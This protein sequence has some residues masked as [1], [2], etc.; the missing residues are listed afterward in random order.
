MKTH[1]PKAGSQALAHYEKGRAAWAAMAERATHVYVADISYGRIPKRRGHWSDKLA[2]IDKDLDAMRA[3][4]A[5]GGAAS[6]GAAAAIA[7]ASAAPNRPKVTCTHTAPQQFSPG[8]PLVL[9][10]T[11][12]GDVSALLHYRHVNQA[13]RWQSMPMT[14][15]GQGFMAA[16]PAGYTNSP[17]PLQYYFE[18][19]RPGAAWLYPAFNVSLS[20]Q[21]YYAVWKRI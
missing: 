8:S 18:L 7:K 6:A 17:F 3:A 1:D 2:G 13:E 16:I 20:N 12:G 11:A 21:P 9:S 15:S 4:I 10:L 14:R 5:Q 19:S